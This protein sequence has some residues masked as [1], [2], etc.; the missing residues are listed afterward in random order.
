MSR[1]I[2]KIIFLTVELVVLFLLNVLMVFFFHHIRCCIFCDE[3]DERFTEENL[4]THYWTDCPVLTN[5]RLCNIV[6]NKSKLKVADITD[7]LVN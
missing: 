4:V 6:S 3:H 7:C 2:G 5:C 1:V